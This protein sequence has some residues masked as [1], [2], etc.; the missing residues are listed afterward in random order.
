ML[1]LRAESSRCPGVAA[2]ADDDND[3]NNDDDDNSPLDAADAR[4]AAG[5]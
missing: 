5:A 2:T 1:E 4:S 3:D